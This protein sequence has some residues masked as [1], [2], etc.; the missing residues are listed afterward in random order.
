MNH[1]RYPGPPMY[2]VTFDHR[3]VAALNQQ[4]WDELDEGY[5]GYLMEQGRVSVANMP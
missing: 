5:R 1:V 4:Q 2:I 3:Y